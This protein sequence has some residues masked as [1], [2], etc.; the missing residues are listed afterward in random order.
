[1]ATKL[2]SLCKCPQQPH[3]FP[4]FAKLLVP[5][6]WLSTQVVLGGCTPGVD[7]PL[8]FEKIGKYVLQMSKHQRIGSC[9]KNSGKDSTK[10]MK[11]LTFF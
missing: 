4:E 8:E 9:L 2:Q 10:N 3:Y 6:S 5:A 1:M 11:N 7:K